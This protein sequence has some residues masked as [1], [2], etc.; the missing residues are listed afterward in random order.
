MEWI[1][2]LDAVSFKLLCMLGG[3]YMVTIHNDNKVVLA[4]IKIRNMLLWIVL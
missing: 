4:I 1:P 2:L 3:M